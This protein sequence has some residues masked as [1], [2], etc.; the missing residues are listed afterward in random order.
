MWQAQRLAPPGVLW[1]CQPYPQLLEKPCALQ[2][3][4]WAPVIVTHHTTHTLTCRS[5]WRPSGCVARP[6]GGA[7]SKLRTICAWSLVRGRW[8]NEPRSAAAT[9]VHPQ[10][11]QILA[12]ALQA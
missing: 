4:L 9:C 12:R 11:A 1:P 8:C 3:T 5:A 10:G 2:I 7:S 6:M